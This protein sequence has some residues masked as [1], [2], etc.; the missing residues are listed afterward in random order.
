[1]GEILYIPSYWFHYIISQDAS[2]QCN[3]RSGDS[4]VGRE[5]ITNCGFYN[6]GNPSKKKAKAYDDESGSQEGSPRNGSGKKKRGLRFA[7]P[8]EQWVFEQ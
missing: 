1:M 4:E 5:Q 3:A 7:P 2:I 8:G 6:G